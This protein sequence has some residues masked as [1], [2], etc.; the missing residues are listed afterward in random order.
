MSAAAAAV[1]TWFADRGWTPMAFQ[2]EAWAAHAA[3]RSGL[4][5][6]P[7]GLGKTLAAWL[8]PVMENWEA[9]DALR[10]LW[11]T[12][13]RAL[14]A[15]T[16]R[17]L[18]EPLADLGRPWTVASRTGDTT[19]SVRAKLRQR[20]Y[21]FGLV[22]TPES[23]SLM[24][25]HDDARNRFGDL[26]CVVC[27]EWHELMGSKRGVQ[28]ELCLARLRQLAPR[29]RT[30]GLSAT[31]GNLEQALEVLL[32][33]GHRDGTIMHSQAEKPV[34]IET[35]LPPT[36]EHFPWSGHLGTRMLGEVVR[37][38][39]AAET[40]LL[41]TNTRSQT[42]IWFQE[43]LDARPDW[44]P[45]LA[46]HHGS[47]ERETREAVEQRLRDGTV[48]CVVCTSSLDLGVDFS[49]VEQVMQLGSPKGIARLLQRAGRS[50]H[51]PGAISRILGVPTNAFELVEFAAAR[52]ALDAGKIE[53]RR[54]L[55][56]ALDVLLQHL[57]TVAVGGGFFPEAM[58]AEVRSTHA[59]SDL[60]DREWQWLLTFITTGGSL[61]AYPQYQK[62][63]ID[64]DGQYRVLDPRV[65]RLHR[66]SIGTIVS[67]TAVSL[68]LANGRRLGSVEEWF[69]SRLKPGQLF[70]FGGKRLELVRHHGLT[71]T[72]RPATR[73][74]ARG[75]IPS[76]Q[77]GKSP[78]STELAE[79]VGLKLLEFRRRGDGSEARP[80][81]FA[82]SDPELRCVAPILRLQQRWSV[83]PAPDELLIETTRTRDGHH[84]YLYPFA[85]R[86]VNEGI[87]M[88]V[89]YRMARDTARSIQVTPNDYGC[90]LHSAS[91]MDFDADE[92]R[93]LLSPDHLLDDLFGCLNTAELGRHQFREVAR[94]AGLVLQGFPGNP[95][96]TRALQVSS[97]LLYDVF[98]KY[99][100]D[101]LL[102]AQAQREVLERQ[103]EITRLQHTLD[104]LQ[105]KSLILQPCERLSPMA[106]PLWADGI[107]SLLSTEDFATRLDRML[108][109]IEAAAE[110]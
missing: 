22:T 29:L 8:G 32:G 96:P 41:F 91:A 108:A 99:D 63:V 97:G 18:Q 38:I 83:L 28:T 92:W 107:S 24:L 51:R 81:R 105:R 33:P 1:E 106:F 71:A 26:A 31:I 27:D 17:S 36:M 25:S 62:V 80:A 100:P 15:D 65:A 84:V 54:P 90:E 9:P 93:I 86:L 34:A 30:W 95:K 13:L 43:L 45:V 44:E 75:Q 35:L 3:G 14:A 23:L 39:E 61:H 88:L 64:T 70:I 89:A 7:T 46:M 72:V 94:V 76:W 59:Y 11:I 73:K 4:I 98:A 42:E 49:P 74:N 55:R 104:T 109:A 10:V 110:G 103:L 6:A 82:P 16:V 58:L 21:P 5:H 20:G 52:D 19:T 57:V 50:G 53:A 87:G 47:L 77:G 78:L 85:G 56:L 48:K 37:R 40:T 79:A 102:L 101:N 2:R 66:L 60:P 67:D 69:I 68:R 12:P